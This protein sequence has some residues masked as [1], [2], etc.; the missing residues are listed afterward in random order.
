MQIK[1]RAQNLYRKVR[2]SD[3]FTIARELKIDLVFRDLPSEVKGL[4]ERVLRRKYIILN[5]NLPEEEWRFV[6]FHELGH[7][8]LHKGINHYFITRETHFVIDRL[9]AQASEF[10]VHFLTAADQVCPGEVSVSY[11]NRCGV[12]EDMHRF[13]KHPK[14]QSLKDFWID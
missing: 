2:T 6:F 4:C 13:F 12:P 11:L 3:I 8:I 7:L 9:E 5:Q 14:Q 10:A 1:R